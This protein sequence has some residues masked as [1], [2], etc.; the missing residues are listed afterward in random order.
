MTNLPLYFK[1]LGF[2][3][4]YKSSLASNAISE[5]G[6]KEN[7]HNPV[8]IELLKKKVANFNDFKKPKNFEFDQKH[9]EV[10]INN[11]YKARAAGKL[12]TSLKN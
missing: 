8:F 9:A 10:F 5:Y 7:S 6:P 2:D 12:F 11:I 3:E 1:S 4:T